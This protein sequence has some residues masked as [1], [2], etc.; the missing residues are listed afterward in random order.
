MNKKK[1]QEK[2]IQRTIRI[3]KKIKAKSGTLPRL[4]VFRSNR[5]IYAQIIDVNKGQV[6]ASANDLDLS[7]TKKEKKTKTEVAF[8]VGQ[9]LAEKGKKA[10]IEKVVF[11]RSFYRYHGRVKSLAEGARDGGLKF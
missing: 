1:K 5:H 7:K 3:R 4:S 6:L 10:N 8:L 9:L 11:D 2:R